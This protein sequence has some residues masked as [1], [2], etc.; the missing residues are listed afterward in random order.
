MELVLQKEIANIS[1]SELS[2]KSL[3]NR[4][5]FY[6]HYADVAAVANDI[7]KDIAEFIDACIDEFSITNVYL[8]THTLFKTLTERLEDNVL[9]KNYIIHST[10]SV[11]VL[12]DIKAIFADKTE[13]SILNKFPEIPRE[14][15]GYPLTFAAAGIIDSYAKWA[16]SGEVPLEELIKEVS[17][18]TEKII[19]DITKRV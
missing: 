11:A 5:T 6:L 10:N 8:S 4:S 15:L 12:A 3:V 7:K 17:E 9:M 14:K 16:K 13:R 1:V 18:I 19:E 2:A